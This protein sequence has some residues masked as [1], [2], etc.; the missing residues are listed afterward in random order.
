MTIVKSNCIRKL[1][2]SVAI[3]LTPMSKWAH[4][5]TMIHTI[6][7][8]NVTILPWTSNIFTWKFINHLCS[9]IRFPW[10]CFLLGRI[11]P[12]AWGRTEQRINSSYKSRETKQVQIIPGDNSTD[13]T[14]EAILVHKNLTQDDME[15]LLQNAA[16]EIVNRVVL[17][18]PS[19]QERTR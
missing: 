17:E 13:K 5:F 14:P 7:W 6:L 15:K 16:K 19:V 8:P 18:L 11:Q 1:P 3:L 9:A 2:S 4:F 12:G 10:K